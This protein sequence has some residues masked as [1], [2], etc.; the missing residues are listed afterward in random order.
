MS[1]PEGF[2]GDRQPLPS[3]TAGLRGGQMGVRGHPM[4]QHY[5]TLAGE[6]AAYK[7]AGINKQQVVVD[8]EFLPAMFRTQSYEIAKDICRHISRGEDYGPAPSRPSTIMRSL[9]QDAIKD[10]PAMMH[11]LVRTLDVRVRD[12]L[13]L[14]RNVADQMFDDEQVNWGRIVSLHAFCGLLAKYC[15]QNFIPDCADDIGNILGDFIVNRLGLWIVTH[16]GW[17]SIIAVYC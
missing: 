12:Q 8:G 5:H 10:K 11:Q 4:A 2:G 17:V 16:G 9:V 13:K 14:V 15:E 7:N 3:S 6:A 1:P